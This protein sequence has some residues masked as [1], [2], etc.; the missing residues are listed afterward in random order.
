MKTRKRPAL[1]GNRP[2]RNAP[3]ADESTAVPP[4]RGYEPA[5]LYLLDLGLLPAPNLEGLREMWAAGG[6]SRR[7]AVI[8]RRWDDL[9]TT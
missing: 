9:V 6:E 2:T 8:A 5:A 7:A 1:A 4:T 3:N